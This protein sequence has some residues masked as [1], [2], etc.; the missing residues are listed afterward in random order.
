MTTLDEG[1]S[2]GQEKVEE[3][4]SSFISRTGGTDEDTIARIEKA[5]QLL[6]MLR[7]VWRSTFRQEGLNSRSSRQMLSQSHSTEQRL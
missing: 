7:P 4:E 3:L 6:A 1:V 2:V 5:R